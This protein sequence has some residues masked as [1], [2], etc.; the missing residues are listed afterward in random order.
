MADGDWT[1]FVTRPISAILIALAVL[2][3]FNP[4]FQKYFSKRKNDNAEI[5]ENKAT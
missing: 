5:D 3:L 2:T 4:L 1:V